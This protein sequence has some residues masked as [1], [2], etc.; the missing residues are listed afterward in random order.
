MCPDSD[1]VT[2]LSL[3]FPCPNLGNFFVSESY[4]ALTPCQQLRI[5]PGCTFFVNTWLP[6]N[7][8]TLPTWEDISGSFGTGYW[9]KLWLNAE[10][11]RCRAM[12]TWISTFTQATPKRQWQISWQTIVP[13]PHSCFDMESQD[14]WQLKHFWCFDVSS[15]RVSGVRPR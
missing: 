10:F 2:H 12:S 1:I 13:S 11:F 9:Q 8:Y 4:P 7:V 15:A 6:I 14:V 3:I 5:I